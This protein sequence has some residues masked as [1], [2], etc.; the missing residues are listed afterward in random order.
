V[1][2]RRAKGEGTIF[3]S[4][5]ERRWI[6]EIT[7]P[8]GRKKKKRSKDRQVVSDWLFAQRKAISDYNQPLDDK[9]TFNEF[10]DKFLEEVAKHTLKEKTYIT[11]ESYLRLH[12]RPDLGRMKLASI[13]SQHIQRLYTK[14][15]GSGLSKKTVHHI[16]GTLRRVLNKAVKRGL[17]QRN[18]CDGVTPPRIDKQVP[19]VWTIEEAKTFLSAVSDHRWYGIYLIALTTGAR[20]GEIL[21]MEWQNINW[22]KGTITI[23]KTI[24]E[25]KGKATITSPKTKL[26]SRTI[27][28]P[29]LVLDLLKENRKSSV[30]IFPSE[31]GNPLSPRNLLRHF[32]SVLEKLDV[33]KIRFHDLRHTAATILLQKDVHPKKV[34]ELLGHSSITLTL[35]TY[36]HIIPGVDNQ[37]AE[38][39]DAVFK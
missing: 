13:Q 3:W 25:I 21:G 28:L 17:I 33:P 7:L 38:E 24:V 14:K 9:T 31:R 30:W 10:A 27:V 35:D 1:T 32:Y 19:S 20:R 23:N 16:H 39:M 6:A 26:S 2:K 22:I 11:Y 12:V 37:V 5:S 36:S 34:Q 4:Q 29:S 18:P 15:L 8:D